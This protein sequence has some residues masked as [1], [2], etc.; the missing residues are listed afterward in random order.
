MSSV[1]PTELATPKPAAQPVALGFDAAVAAA[2]EVE[3][4]KFDPYTE[5]PP[6]SWPVRGDES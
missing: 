1:E 3:P 5:W 4:T 6:E 2:V